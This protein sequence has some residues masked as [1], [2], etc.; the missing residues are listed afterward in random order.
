MV[1]FK[2]EWSEPAVSRV[3][4]KV[5]DC[6][7]PPSMPGVGWALGCD[8]EFLKQLQQYWVESYDWRAA[9]ETLNRYPQ[10]LEEVDGLAIHFVHVVGESQGRRPL[11]LTHGWPGSHYEFWDVIEALAFP[12][13]FGGKPEDAFDLVIPSLPGF[14]FSGKPQKVIGQRATAALWNKLMT[15]VLGYKRYRAQGG[16]W[17]SLVTSWLGRNHADAVEAIHLNMLGFR[18]MDPPRD[19]AEKVWAQ[20]AEMAR[21][22]FG[23]YA[24]V[25]TTKPHSIAWAAADNPLGQAAWITERFH[26]WADLRRRGFEQVFNMDHLLTNIM[27]YVMTESFASAACYYP[28]VA[29]DGFALMPHGERCETPTAYADVSGDALQPSPPRS[30]VELT[31]KLTRWSNP[32]EGGHFLAMESPQWFIDEMRAWGRE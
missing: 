24:A 16:D 17:G 12:S 31:Y 11:L 27:I 22:K 19:D 29:M 13:R 25:Q 32:P 10:F 20:Q 9:L 7:L 6:R 23:A 5:K 2:V 14:G 4:Q 28:G 8:A 1:P 21:G 15:E 18:S 3:L 30:R 26:D